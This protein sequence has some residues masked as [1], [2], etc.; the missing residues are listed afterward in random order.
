MAAAE[1]AEVIALQDH[2]VKLE[3]GQRLLAFQAQL[4]RVETQHAVDGKVDADLPQQ[5]DI[6]QGVQPVGVVGEHRVGRSIAEAQEWGEAAADAGHVGVDGIVDQ[7]LTRLV[8]AGWVA[9][10]GGA[11]AEQD[12][13][14]VAVLLQKA[15]DHD[16]HEAADMQAVSRA[17]EADIGGYR[18]SLHRGAQCFG[19]GALE[20]EAAR[21]G[22]I[23]ESVGRHA[24][25]PVVCGC[26][27]T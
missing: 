3:E 21:G 22:F 1:F 4:D 26:G 7:Q 17:V 16:L 8:L 6:A 10:A 15:K 14:A 5:G 23:K 9:D 12:E 20:D 11:A 18:A 13:G 27:L 2:V 25:G 19:V 24:G